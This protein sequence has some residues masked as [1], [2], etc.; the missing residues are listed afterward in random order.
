MEKYI[1]TNMKKIYFFISRENVYKET[2]EGDAKW[3]NL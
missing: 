1:I 2:C 3:Q